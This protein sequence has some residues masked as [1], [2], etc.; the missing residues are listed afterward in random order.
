M[1][2]GE[3]RCMKIVERR[4]VTMLAGLP[5]CQLVIRVRINLLLSFVCFLRPVLSPSPSLQVLLQ[6]FRDG[7]FSLHRP[8]PVT[9]QVIAI[10]SNTQPALTHI[11]C[12]VYQTS[13]NFP[14]FFFL[15]TLK[16]NS[17][18]VCIHS[19]FNP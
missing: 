8:L 13:C 9:R 3:S 18:Q 4:V 11:F 10:D 7:T 16:R 17:T 19:D 1:E 15:L 5:V 14:L 12:T 6:T 2:V